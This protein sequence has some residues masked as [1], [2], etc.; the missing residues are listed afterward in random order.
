MEKTEVV[1]LANVADVEPPDA[2]RLADFVERGGGLLVF[3]GDRVATSS[4]E[5]EAAGL[6]VGT[7][8]GPA[9]ASDVPWRLE[10][11]QSGHPVFKPFDDPESGDLRRPVFTSITRIK[12]DPR[13]R[14]LAWFRG[15]EP[16]LLER[17]LGRGKVL[18]FT[19]SCDRA[20][21]DWPRGRMYLPI[22]HQMAGYLSGGGEE[23]R[24]RREKIDDT[25][26]PGVIESD[27]VVHVVNTDPL[28]SE[29]A[30]CTPSEF[31]QRFGFSPPEPVTEDIVGSRKTVSDDRSRNDELWPWFAL[32]LAGL[33]LVE[34]FLANRTAA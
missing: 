7:I 34:N 30:R 16:A 3:T 8:L 18:W 15:D 19:S 27:G 23:G 1:V 29:T 31:A 17:A 6:G 14:V 24:I 26:K 33:L 13:A 9:T 21:G 12:V 5:L 20:W 2:K 10:R 32:S 28:E 4:R 11:W 22:V 25:R